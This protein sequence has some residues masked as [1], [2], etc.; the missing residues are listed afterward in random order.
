MLIINRYVNP[1]TNKTTICV[2]E[3][4]GHKVVKSY[5]PMCESNIDL[6]K[7]RKAMIFNVA[8]STDLLKVNFISI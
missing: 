4:K 3:M 6:F 2:H 7:G 5:S 8:R 1:N